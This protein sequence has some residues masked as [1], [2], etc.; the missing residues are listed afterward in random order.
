MIANLKRS[1]LTSI[2]TCY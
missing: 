1:V 2:Y